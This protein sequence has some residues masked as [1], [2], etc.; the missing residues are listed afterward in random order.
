MN[1]TVSN[2]TTGHVAF[3]HI[4]V[5]P[6][7]VFCSMITQLQKQ[8]HFNVGPLTV[9]MAHKQPSNLSIP[10]SKSLVNQE[11]ERIKEQVRYHNEQR[12]FRL[13]IERLKGL[14]TY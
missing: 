9:K 3:L 13:E 8:G 11:K 7:P 10:S 2:R 1:P 5:D 6:S 12:R 14:N 4:N